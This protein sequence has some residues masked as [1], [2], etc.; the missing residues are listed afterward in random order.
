M[1]NIGL[2]HKYR[3]YNAAG[4]AQCCV[5]PARG[6]VFIFPYNEYYMCFKG[7]YDMQEFETLKRVCK[8]FTEE[9]LSCVEN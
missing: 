2:L 9:E 1:T 4:E 8:W 6:H 5:I 3:L 7:D